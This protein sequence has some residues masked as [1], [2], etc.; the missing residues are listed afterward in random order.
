MNR[1][2]IPLLTPVMCLNCRKEYT[3]DHLYLAE[4]NE[5]QDNGSKIPMLGFLAFCT[6]KCVLECYTPQGHC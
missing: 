5:V 1:V 2:N 6:P 3:P 4:Y